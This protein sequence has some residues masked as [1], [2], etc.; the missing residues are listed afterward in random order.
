MRTMAS[1]KE[2]PRRPADRDIPDAAST[3]PTKDTI[4]EGLPSK[5]NA[6]HV[7][8]LVATFQTK[9][10]R[11]DQLAESLNTIRDEFQNLGKKYVCMMS[12]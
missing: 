5:A 4:P 9:R 7:K 8:E 6:A 2:T 11:L 3:A 12:I 10:A 1:A